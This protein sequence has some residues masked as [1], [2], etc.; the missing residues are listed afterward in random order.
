MQAPPPLKIGR[1]FP[2]R[3]LEWTPRQPAGPVDYL[4][5]ARRGPA[6]GHLSQ[7]A[8]CLAAF[9]VRLPI[10]GRKG[11]ASVPASFCPPIEPLL[12][13]SPGSLLAGNSHVVLLQL[14]EAVCHKQHTLHEIDRRGVLTAGQ[15]RNCPVPTD[16]G[17]R[18]L[19]G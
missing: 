12:S 11:T 6:S 9:A 13:A 14:V 8:P 2:Q 17:D 5:S 18:A 10:V 19:R 1:C 16:N 7:S 15:I 3:P 4:S